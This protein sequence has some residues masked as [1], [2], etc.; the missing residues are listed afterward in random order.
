MVDKDRLLEA[1][2]RAF[3]DASERGGIGTLSEKMLHKTLKYYFEPDER[4]HEVEYLGSVADILNEDGII[5]I[6]TRSFDKLIP[7]L[8]K[9]LPEKRVTVVYPI[10]ERKSICRIDLETG[11]SLPPRKSSKK[12]RATDALA[13]I[14]MIRRFIPCNNLRIFLVFLD[15]EETRMLTRIKKVGRH[16]TDKIDCAPTSINRILELCN[17]RDFALLLP[18]KLPSE[19]TASEFEGLSRIH[20]IGLHN[21]L[22]FLMQMG[23]LAREKRGGRAYIYTIN[24]L[25]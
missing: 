11:E 22:M 6:Q 24:A 21:S 17:A 20:S 23:I 19:F 9:F 14:A 13:E 10:I 8:E 2:A 7:K 4:N 18:K 3:I 25:N 12:G 1:R 5:E 16:K 15:A